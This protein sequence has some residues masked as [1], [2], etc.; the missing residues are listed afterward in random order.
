MDLAFRKLALAICLAGASILT[1]PGVSRAEVVVFDRVTTVQTDIHLIVLTKGLLFA[2]GGRLVDI[3]LDGRHLKKILTGGDGFG[4]LKYTPQTAGLKEIR[5]RSDTGSG[6]GLLLVL[7][8]NEKAIVIDIESAFQEAAFSYDV[9]EK[10]RQAVNTLSKNYKIIYLS[11]FIGKGIGRSWLKREKF[12]ESVILRWQGSETLT[13]LEES[14]VQL[15][16]VIGSEDVIS[17]AEEQHIENRYTFEETKSGKTV[18]DWDEILQLLQPAL[19]E[20]EE[21]NGKEQKTEDGK[22]NCGEKGGS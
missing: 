6:T 2:E 12:P 14:G 21:G 11:R 15:Q 20:G 9:R 10:C 13:A 4:Y 5:A 1:W 7:G 16:A 19:P 3:F 18:K 17:A 8:K 22:C